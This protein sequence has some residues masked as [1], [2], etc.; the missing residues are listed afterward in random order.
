VQAVG[1]VEEKA[2]AAGAAPELAHAPE[3]LPVH[4][5][6]A[7]DVQVPTEDPVGAPADPNSGGP[8]PSLGSDKGNGSGQGDEGRRGRSH[9]QP[10]AVGQKPAPAKPPL[11]VPAPVR[12]GPPPASQQGAQ[13]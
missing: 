7:P 6:H 10:I 9:F 4:W 5:K 11:D 8:A 1:Q 2:P 13:S 3:E 12:V